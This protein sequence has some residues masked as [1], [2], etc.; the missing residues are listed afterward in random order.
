MELR[1]HEF[2]KILGWQLYLVCWPVVHVHDEF[3]EASLRSMTA[4]NTYVELAKTV[5]I[6]KYFI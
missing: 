6:K 5:T 4:G 2:V 3:R 1:G